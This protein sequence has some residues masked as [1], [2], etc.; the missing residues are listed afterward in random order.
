MP[1]LPAPIAAYIAAYNAKDVGAM[2]AVLSDTVTFQ[3]IA[4]GQT[5]THT[6]GRDAFAELAHFGAQAFTTRH[7]EVTNAITV[8]NL[9]LIEV[10]YTALVAMDL[11]NGWT[12]GQKLAF[13]GASA[14]TVEGGLITA[15]TDE[16]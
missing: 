4:E 15:I 9:T 12:K 14:F 1:N 6:T 3:N 16:S 10:S 11:P 5:T 2:L 13:K 8:A 7:Q